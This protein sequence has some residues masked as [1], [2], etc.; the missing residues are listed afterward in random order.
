MLKTAVILAAG[1]GSRLREQTKNKPKG[2]IILH[3][4]PIV[5]ESILKLFE[6]GIERI[7]IGTGYLSESYEKLARK[8][9]AIQ[10]IKNNDFASTGSMYTLYNMREY[11]DDDFLMLDSDLVYDKSGLNIIIQNSK[12]DIILGSSKTNS[13]DESYID[14]DERHYLLNVS[15][16]KGELNSVYAEFIGITK[17]SHETFQELIRFSEERF[18]LNPM[19]DYEYA[20]VGISKHIKIAVLKIEDYSWCEIDNEDQLKRAFTLY[21]EI[22][23]G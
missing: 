5:E 11:I 10:C 3:E 7:L 21:P 23:K 17:I 6:S 2:F 22:T 12:N 18:L 4:K 20:L 13:G 9:S 1:L 19:L 8:Y 14:V 15:K 16:K